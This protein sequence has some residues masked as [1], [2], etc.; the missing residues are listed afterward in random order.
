[1]SRLQP[2][3]S[4]DGIFNDPAKGRLVAAAFSDARYQR[5]LRDCEASYRP[6][7]QV[8]PI[9][10]QAGLDPE[11]V[12]A[13][14]KLGRHGRR[15]VLPF[16]DDAGQ[17]L[18]YSVPDAVQ[19]ELTLIDQ[20]LAGNITLDG[21][22]PPGDDRDRYIFS[23][24]M[25]EAIASSN[26]EGA[27]TVHRVAKDMLRKS[28][29]P[30]TNGERM[31]ANNYRAILHVREFRDRPL[32]VDFLLELQRILTEGTLDRPD[33]AGR[34]R[35][36]SDRVTIE[37]VYGE[38]VHTPPPAGE[39]PD[40]LKALCEFANDPWQR[41]DPFI[42]PVTRAITLHFQVAYDHPFCDGNGRTARV[43]FYW[44]M[45]RSGYWLFEFLPVSRLIY[46]SAGQYARAF[47]YVETDEFDL[48]YFLAYH[49]RVI[50][51]ARRD[52]AQF[53]SRKRREAVEANRRFADGA[54]NERQRLVLAHLVGEPDG[55]VTIESHQVSSQVS[56]FTARADLLRLE[57]LGYL[58]RRRLGKKFV[59]E[60]APRLRE[61]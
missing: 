35:T 34:L 7:R 8:R 24:L 52:L 13:L 28:R 29:A 9:A 26:L 61:R 45:L 25:E 44:S 50:G 57:E 11:I 3:P 53:L 49:A 30:R 2:P 23:S 39:L 18:H 6:W 20:Q 41:A 43:L 58:Q 46:A 51:L 55:E 38:T 4:V 14:L 10:R 33:Q 54:L 15:R 17:P 37:D 19:Q 47:L 27:S 12:W 16:R 36:E 59:F 5:V 31:I 42:H 60:A 21:D 22:G 1:M 40:R 48:T 56:Y 32:T